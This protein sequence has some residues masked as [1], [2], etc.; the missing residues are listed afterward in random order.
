MKVNLIYRDNTSIVEGYQT[1]PLDEH[2]AVEMPQ[3]I[4]EWFEGGRYCYNGEWFNNT[5]Y[6]PPVNIAHLKALLTSY[7]YDMQQVDM[8]GIERDDYEEKKAM[9]RELILQ[10]KDL[11]KNQPQYIAVYK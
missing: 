10:I 7:K 8:F 1:Y 5:Q 9:C 11:E 6:K 3:H 4:E 2:T